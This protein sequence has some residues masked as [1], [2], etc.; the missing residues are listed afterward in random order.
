MSD[1][2]KHEE[3]IRELVS[4][5]TAAREA[6]TDKM[7]E[8]LVDTVSGGIEFLDRLNEVETQEAFI[9]L[10]EKITELHK[11]GAMDTLF[12]TISVIHAMKSALT[13]NILE[14]MFEALEKTT[15]T[16]ANEGTLK[17]VEDTK[18]SLQIAANEYE[19]RNTSGGLFSTINLLSKPDS[20]RSLEFLL[21]FSKQLEKRQN[22]L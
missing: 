15:D 16:L 7:V 9:A 22:E 5:S 6:L 13:D 10:I 2:L 8:R 20:R 1:D 17:L 19:N 14:R 4:L 3:S 18:E 11:S 12:E 21:A